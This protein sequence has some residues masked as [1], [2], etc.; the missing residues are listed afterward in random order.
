M[1]MELTTNKN[2]HGIKKKIYPNYAGNNTDFNLTGI[3]ISGH[4]GVRSV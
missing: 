4:F 2:C 1:K 3:S